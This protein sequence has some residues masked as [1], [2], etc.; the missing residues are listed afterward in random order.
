MISSRVLVG[1][2][3]GRSQRED[4]GKG[5]KGEDKMGRTMRIERSGNSGIFIWM[6]QGV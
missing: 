6:H 1:P 2:G 3:L 4:G 5:T